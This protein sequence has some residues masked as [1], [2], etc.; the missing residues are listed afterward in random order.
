[1]MTSQS[2]KKDLNFEL[3]LLPFFDILSTCIC[4]LL[5]TVA[6]IHIGSLDVSQ[7]MGGQSTQET[8]NPPSVWAYLE[9]SGK[10]VLSLKD[11]TNGAKAGDVVIAGQGA[12]LR[13]GE[14]AGQIAQLSVRYPEVKTA[15]IMP[16]KVTAYDDI[17]HVMDSFKKSGVRDIGISP[18]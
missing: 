10:V 15:L 2:N 1:M 5:M 8:K 13:W 12:T 16:S 3:N 14:V 17:V 6:W 18:L 11:L 9:D 4:F 7:A